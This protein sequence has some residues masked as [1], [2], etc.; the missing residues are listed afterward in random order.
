MFEDLSAQVA[1][2]RDMD[3]GYYPAERCP[4]GHPVP[5]TDPRLYGGG[6]GHV[7]WECRDLALRA[8]L[9]P[10][11]VWDEEHPDPPGMKEAL[12]RFNAE[13]GPTVGIGKKVEELPH[14]EMRI[15]RG[16]PKPLAEDPRL[17]AEVEKEFRRGHAG[18]VLTITIDADGRVSAA[19]A[20]RGGEIACQG[21]TEAVAR[22]KAFLAAARVWGHLGSSPL[23]E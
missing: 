21:P 13:M 10:G 11:A 3:D 9:A 14:P 16:P 8:M 7:C 6:I 15:H 23:I 4:Q 1:A 12:R 17:I 19:W 5:W 22:C 18:A 2:M 20:Y